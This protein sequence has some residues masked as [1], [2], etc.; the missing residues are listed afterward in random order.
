MRIRLDGA[1]ALRE[2]DEFAASVEALCL[3]LSRTGRPWVSLIEIGAFHADGFRPAVV[4]DIM[5]LARDCGHERC[6][7]LMQDWAWARAFAD[8]MLAAKADDQVRI[9]VVPRTCSVPYTQAHRWMFEGA[10]VPLLSSAA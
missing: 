8:A 4:T 6:A 9:F 3:E 2:R 7:I 10:V 1:P 5:R